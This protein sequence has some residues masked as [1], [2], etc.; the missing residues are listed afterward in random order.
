MSSL[1][2]GRPRGGDG[3]E[4]NSALFCGGEISS[5]PSALL[6]EQRSYASCD[7]GVEQPDRAT[8][9]RAV[10]ALQR[11]IARIPWMLLQRFKASL[12]QDFPK[13]Q[14]LF[15]ALAQHMPRPLSSLNVLQRHCAGCID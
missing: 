14:N 13:P 11:R 5:Q 1:P 7:E 2:I 12:R 3:I 10:N 4:S 9:Q 15:F 6:M 8:R